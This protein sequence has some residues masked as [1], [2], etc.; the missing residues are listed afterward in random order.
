MKCL[1]GP[2]VVFYVLLKLV[3]HGSAIYD[4]VVHLFCHHH[5]EVLADLLLRALGHSQAARRRTSRPLE[6]LLLRRR[7]SR[8]L[9]GRTLRLPHGVGLQGQAKTRLESQLSKTAKPNMLQYR[10]SC[11]YLVL[12]YRVKPAT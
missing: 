3:A 7:T 9:R 11:L 6:N 10:G 5:L 1:R 12:G 2:V 8:R 4:D